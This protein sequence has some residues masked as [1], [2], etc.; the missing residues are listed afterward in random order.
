VKQ[1]VFVPTIGFRP[2]G[3]RVL[4]ERT[5]TAADGT[6]LMV[7]AAAAAPDRTDLVITTCFHERHPRTLRPPGHRAPGDSRHRRAKP[8]CEL[9]HRR[10]R[11]GRD[12]RGVDDEELRAQLRLQGVEDVADVA[13]AYIEHDGRMS[14]LRRDGARPEARLGKA[15]I[16]L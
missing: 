4:R 2:A 8:R 7:L 13:H 15:G 11:D 6:R 9:H 16:R 14:V 1:L 3:T 12:D 5:E 10:G